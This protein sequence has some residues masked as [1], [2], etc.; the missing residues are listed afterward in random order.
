MISTF[1]RYFMSP[2]LKVL[3]LKTFTVKVWQIREVILGEVRQVANLH[4]CTISVCT[5][6]SAGLNNTPTDG[7]MRWELLLVG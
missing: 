7:M 6:L 1:C 4:N 2:Q 3:A 5:A